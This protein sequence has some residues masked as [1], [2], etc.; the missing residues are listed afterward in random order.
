MSRFHHNILV[1]GLAV[2]FALPVCAARPVAAGTENYTLISALPLTIRTPG[3][4]RLAANLE[5]NVAGNAITV[6]CDNVVIDLS[7]FTIVNRFNS[8][9]AAIVAAGRK[10][11]TIR[12][13]CLRGFDLGVDLRMGTALVV[14]DLL[15]VETRSQGVAI[16]ESVGGVVRRCTL[17]STDHTLPI[18][19]KMSGRTA[20]VRDNLITGGKSGSMTG[21]HLAGCDHAIIEGNVISNEFAYLTPSARG[22]LAE[23]NYIVVM[24][25]RISYMDT[26][27]H[28]SSTNVGSLFR[29]NVADPC[30]TKYVNGTDGGNNF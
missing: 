5:L 30:Q 20:I 27:I 23:G 21:I 4:Y 11:V 1:V 16:L 9:N 13:G 18:G 17:A 3:G 19:I 8:N 28:F 22:I 15:L 6:G 2:L 25:N 24:G 29:D 10:N 7:G 14:E 26:G 12:N